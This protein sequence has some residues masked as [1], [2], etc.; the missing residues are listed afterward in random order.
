MLEERFNSLP[1]HSWLTK[2]NSACLVQALGTNVA[3]PITG[4]FSTLTGLSRWGLSQ[5]QAKHPDTRLVKNL[6][7]PCR[8]YSPPRGEKVERVLARSLAN[9]SSP[10]RWRW[11]A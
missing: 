11:K 3:V 5:G 9:K 7:Y 2:I 1:L 8:L 6:T 10:M 4:V